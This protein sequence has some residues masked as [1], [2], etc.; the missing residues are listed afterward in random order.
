MVRAGRAMLR[1]HGGE[2]IL[3]D[4]SVLLAPTI[5]LTTWGVDRGSQELYDRIL[6]QHASHHT[7]S[8]TLARLDDK[9]ELELCLRRY[10]ERSGRSVPRPRTWLSEE[11]AEPDTSP[12]DELV[13]V[14]PSGGGSCE[15]IE[16]LPRPLQ[17]V[18]MR[19]YRP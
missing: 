3:S 15:G 10:E 18:W 17:T 13:I 7:E 2:D 14:K 11:L 5:V 16:I 12:D 8:P 6:E 4:V 19:T 1:R 9:S